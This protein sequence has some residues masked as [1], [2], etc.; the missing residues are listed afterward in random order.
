VI[1][2]ISTALAPAKPLNR[3]NTEEYG[4]KVF[5]L[6]PLPGLGST[7]VQNLGIGEFPKE[8]VES[9]VARPVDLIVADAIRNPVFRAEVE[10]SKERLYAA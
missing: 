4:G 5:C 1:S 6:G 2:G 8:A 3:R 9:I 7:P 10:R